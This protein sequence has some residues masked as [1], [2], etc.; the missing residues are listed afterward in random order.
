MQQKGLQ[1][2]MTTHLDAEHLVDLTLMPRRSRQ[3]RG[4]RIE[5]GRLAIQQG[6]TPHLIES[7]AGGTPQQVDDDL[8]PASSWSIY[9]GEQIQA[10]EAVRD[11]ARDLRR[12]R[13]PAIPRWAAHAGTAR[14]TRASTSAS[15]LGGQPGTYAVT[16]MTRSTPLVTE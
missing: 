10:V 8:D 4:D 6:V 7:T 13:L 3:D 2:G 11:M 16:G 15:G 14:A 12:P 5:H 1:V 9:G